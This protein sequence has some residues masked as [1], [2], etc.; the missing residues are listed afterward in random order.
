MKRILFIILALASMG[1]YV[2]PGCWGSE[3][4]GHPK[5]PQEIEQEDRERSRNQDPTRELG[6]DDQKEAYEN[7]EIDWAS[8]E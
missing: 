1:F 8:F 5:S 3:C 4:P 6:D 7:D 2:H